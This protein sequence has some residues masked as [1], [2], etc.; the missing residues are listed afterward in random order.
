MAYRGLFPL[1][2][3]V[4]GEVSAIGM[5]RRGYKRRDEATQF[6]TLSRADP[7]AKYRL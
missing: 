4:R 2:R 3:V 5:S 6:A 7:L 1:I